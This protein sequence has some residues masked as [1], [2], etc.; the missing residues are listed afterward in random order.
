MTTY[1]FDKDIVWCGCFK[2]TLDEFE[3]KVN[4]THKDNEQYLKEYIGF[5]N[6]LKSLK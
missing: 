1:D 2:G 3:A 4:D 6:Y 5:I